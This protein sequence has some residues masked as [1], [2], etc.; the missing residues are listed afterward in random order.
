[1]V[2]VNIISHF[3][4]YI[5]TTLPCWSSLLYRIELSILAGF[6]TWST[7]SMRKQRSLFLSQAYY[8]LVL[9]IYK[10]D[11]KKL[12]LARWLNTVI[13][14][15]FWETGGGALSLNNRLHRMHLWLV[16]VVITNIQPTR[17]PEG[18]L[19]EVYWLLICHFLRDTSRND[20][21]S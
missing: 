3:S 9:L 11:I 8:Y 5:R 4:N 15:A 18:C 10:L 13:T 16:S 19:L 12:S 2:Q 1:M 7:L 21:G 17:H 6:S 14:E 20:D